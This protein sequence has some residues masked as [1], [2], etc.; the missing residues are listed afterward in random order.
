MPIAVAKPQ[1]T[2]IFARRGSNAPPYSMVT[3]VPNRMMV[4]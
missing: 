3:K 1:I 2:T 4:Q